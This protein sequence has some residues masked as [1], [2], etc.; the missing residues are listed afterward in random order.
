MFALPS[1][2]LLAASLLLAHPDSKSI[3]ILEVGGDEVRGT[4]LVQVLSILEV[5]PELDSDED[6]GLSDDEAAAG[7]VAILGYLA[8]HYTLADASG[9][10]LSRATDDLQL[11]PFD[12]AFPF[13]PQLVEVRST[14]LGR[15]DLA[16]LQV[17]MDLFLETSPAHFD[18]L[19]VT[20]SGCRSSHELLDGTRSSVQLFP[21]AALFNVALRD[22]A[23]LGWALGVLLCAAALSCAAKRER[24]WLA[25]SLFVATAAAAYVA[26][27]LWGIPLEGRTLRLCLPLAS[28]WLGADQWMHRESSR[29]LE[30]LLF[31][32][33]AGLG[34][35]LSQG[36]LLDAGRMPHLPFLAAALV[37]A[38]LAGCLAGMIGGRRLAAALGVTGLALFL[39]RAF[40]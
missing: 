5:L 31:G 34:L 16:G 6:G 24:R 26:G 13:E 8:G 38:L 1:T 32:A 20:W 29:V 40:G 14:W 25:P 17:T 4:Q 39:L 36:E 37:P 30:G 9:Q 3:T 2:A 23:R 15:G 27:Q 12:P 35:A 10:A 22:G 28:A 18:S 21:S 7:R 33:L 11:V 19:E